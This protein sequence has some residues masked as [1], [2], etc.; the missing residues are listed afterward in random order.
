MV[1][2]CETVVSE[3]E[4]MKLV[5]YYDYEYGVPVSEFELTRIKYSDKVFFVTNDVTLTISN[6]YANGIEY[7]ASI[8]SRFFEFDQSYTV[9]IQSKRP[10]EEALSDLKAACLKVINNYGRVK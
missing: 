8:P 5:A 7:R 10:M 9:T 3:S 2:D 6:D 4:G 1:H